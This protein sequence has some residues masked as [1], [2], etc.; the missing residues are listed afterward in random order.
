MV[1]ILGVSLKFLSIV[2]NKLQTYIFIS[3]IFKDYWYL[4][5]KSKQKLPA[6][7]FAAIK[8]R[9]KLDTS[10]FELMI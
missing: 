8:F 6:D 4:S 1:H 7:I 10:S 9:L 2:I 3:K 5:M